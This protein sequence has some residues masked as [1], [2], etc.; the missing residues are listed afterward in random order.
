MKRILFFLCVAAIAA[1]VSA[2]TA[3]QAATPSSPKAKTSTASPASGA[4]KAIEPWIKLPPGVPKLAHGPLRIPLS[5]RYE[6]IKIGT[7]PVGEN[8]KLWHIEYTGWRAA[9]GV[10]FDSWENHRMPIM[11]KDGKPE[12]GPD[13]KPKM[14]APQLM[15]FPQGEGRVLPSFDYAFTGMR[16]G[17]MRRIFI[18]WQLAYGARGIPARGADFPGIPPKSDLIFDVTLVNVTDIPATPMRPPMGGMPPHP[19]AS[20]QPNAAPGAK[21]ATPAAPASKPASSAPAQPTATAQPATSAQ[22]A[23]PAQPQTQPK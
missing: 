20:F 19:G 16:V 4:T 23:A 11:G 14:S 21:P 18:P 2:Q 15:E 10:K 3:H 8:G 7:G 12:L 9:D 6:D 22:P 17:G 1:T 5:V 13:G